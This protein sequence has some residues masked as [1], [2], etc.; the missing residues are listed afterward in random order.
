MSMRLRDRL[1]AYPKSV[2]AIGILFAGTGLLDLYW[3]L[4]P[5]LGGT[6]RWKGDDLEIVGIGM[7]AVVGG[8]WTLKGCNWARWLLAI[9]MVLHILLSASSLSTVA[10]HV[11]IFVIVMV[12]LFNPTASRYFRSRKAV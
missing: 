12:A 9:W 11:V 5:L 10:I 6:A 4:S 1:R 7:A 2:L 8:M 3:G